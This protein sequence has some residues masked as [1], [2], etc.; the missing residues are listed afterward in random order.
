LR[1]YFKAPLPD[2]L[3]AI[4]SFAEARVE[5]LLDAYEG[6]RNLLGERLRTQVVPGDAEA[7]AVFSLFRDG[8]WQLGLFPHRA[9][10]PRRV[11]RHENYFR[12]WWA[13]RHTWP[14]PDPGARKVWT[15]SRFALFLD[16]PER[17]GA[18][19][20]LSELYEALKAGGCDW[21]HSH[22]LAQEIVFAVVNKECALLG[23][24]RRTSI[25]GLPE[26]FFPDDLLPIGIT[27]VRRRLHAALGAELYRNQYTRAEAERIRAEMWARGETATTISLT[28]DSRV[29]DEGK[30]RAH[31]EAQ[32]GRR[33]P[34][35]EPRSARGLRVLDEALDVLESQYSSLEH[36]YL[37]LQD[38]PFPSPWRYFEAT[39]SDAQLARLLDVLFTHILGEYPTF[40]Q[41][42]FSALAELFP[43]ANSGPL[44]AVMHYARPSH[45]EQANLFGGNLTYGFI[46]G[47]PGADVTFHPDPNPFLHRSG[48]EGW[49]RSPG[50]KRKL[51]WGY[52]I[53]GF[54]SIIRPHMEI[55]L[56]PGGIT[57]GATDATPVRTA[58]YDL[59]LRE[60]ESIG[61]D[62]QT[63][64]GAKKSA[65][66]SRVSGR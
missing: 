6:I 46:H 29:L 3:P 33:F 48:E 39:Y 50:G 34:L 59:M 31:A 15:G 43:L 60:L 41:R 7:G 58:L 4:E 44:R 9:G 37:P 62:D 47:E 57:G 21:R 55:P 26:I 45:P 40:V 42:N 36:Y 23:Y 63:F 16:N 51:V 30:R 10:D 1:L 22:L 14:P 8:H 13:A 2:H 49:V 28:Y 19:L 52:A 56:E 65:G 18:A 27:D 64:E 66:T 53:A 35:P 38:N 32:Q 61:P 54:G 12:A 25:R 11:V 5:R 24:P 17:R 20:L